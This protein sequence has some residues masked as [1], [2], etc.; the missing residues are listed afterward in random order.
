MAQVAFALPIVPGKEGLDRQT[1]DEL[2]GIRRDEYEQAL[3]DSG[4]RRHA[5]WHQH[6]PDGTVAVVY[7]EAEDESGVAKFGS[8]AEPLNEWFREQM[9]EVHGIDIGEAKLEIEKIHDHRL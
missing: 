1:F 7:I 5:I 2:E 8:A 4:I 3:R 9:K 6:T